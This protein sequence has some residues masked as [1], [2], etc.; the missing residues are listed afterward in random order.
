MWQHDRAFPADWSEANV[1]GWFQFRYWPARLPEATFSVI[2]SIGPEI[3]DLP[4]RG[5]QAYV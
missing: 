1:M 4:T 3:V 5:D 2:D